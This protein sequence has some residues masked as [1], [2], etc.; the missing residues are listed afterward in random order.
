[1]AFISR[2]NSARNYI[3]HLLQ[4]DHRN[5]QG[6]GFLQTNDMAGYHV[7]YVTTYE[8]YEEYVFDVPTEPQSVLNV[9]FQRRKDQPYDRELMENVRAQLLDSIELV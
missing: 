7:D 8:V 5:V 2:E 3:E 6:V 9:C 4:T 1:M